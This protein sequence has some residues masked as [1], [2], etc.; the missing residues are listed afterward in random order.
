MHP[1]KVEYSITP[2]GKRSIEIIDIIRNYSLGLMKEFK[3]EEK[4][5]KKN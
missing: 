4:P 5:K 3:I 2:L 1:P